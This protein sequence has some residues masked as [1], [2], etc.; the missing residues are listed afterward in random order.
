MWTHHA[1][2]L[3]RERLRRRATCAT[4]EVLVVAVVHHLEVDLV[5]ERGANVLG[6][7]ADRELEDAAV[8]SGTGSASRANFE[9]EEI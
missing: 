7:D 6:R 9:E 8:F 3:L 5:A 2:R 4:T 1:E